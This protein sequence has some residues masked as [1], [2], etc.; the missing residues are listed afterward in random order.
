MRL[1]TLSS[2]A[3]RALEGAAVIGLLIAM[4][5]FIEWTSPAP[6]I[7]NEAATG[8]GPCET[9]DLQRVTNRNGRLAIVR[10]ATCYDFESVWYYVVLVEDQKE[11][12]SAPAVA[13]MYE[14]ED[15]ADLGRGP[16]RPT[17]VWTGASSLSITEA[18][19]IDTPVL[20]KNR[21]DGVSIHYSFGDRL[22]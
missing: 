14:P 4:V 8:T 9:S 21:I 20:Q 19:Q 6:P 16:S 7:I 22:P 2:R 15:L 1:P 17:L 11:P 3:S 18:G 5:F 10:A 12:S 13:L